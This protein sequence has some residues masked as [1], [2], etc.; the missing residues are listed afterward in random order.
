M[1]VWEDDEIGVDKWGKSS[2]P[3]EGDEVGQLAEGV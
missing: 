1:T 2:G 3:K